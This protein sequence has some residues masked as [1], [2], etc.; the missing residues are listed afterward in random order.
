MKGHWTVRHIIRF[1]FRPTGSTAALVALFHTARTL[2]STN[3]FAHVC[4]LFQN[5]EYDDDDDDDDDDVIVC[6]PKDESED[7]AGYE[8]YIS[9]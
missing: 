4:Q 3:Q 5:K 1:A 7:E 8:R 2:L 6:L 9:K